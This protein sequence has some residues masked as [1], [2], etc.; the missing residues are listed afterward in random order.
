MSRIITSLLTEQEQL[1]PADS[2]RTAEEE[3]NSE[4]EFED[5]EA[6]KLEGETPR[7]EDSMIEE[8]L[9]GESYRLNKLFARSDIQN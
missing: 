3:T 9:L 4:L 1:P 5:A 6:Y 2:H 7:G 8:V